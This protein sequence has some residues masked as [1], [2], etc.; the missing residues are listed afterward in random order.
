MRRTPLLI[1]AC[2]SSLATAAIAQP[3]LEAAR[4]AKVN[5]IAKRAFATKS[6]DQKTSACFVRSYDAAHLARHPKQ[7]V[8]AMKVLVAAEKLE[9]EES[10]SFSFK[11][12]AQVRDRK[13]DSAAAMDCGYAEASAVK[14]EG[15]LISCSEGCEGGPG[16]VIALA[17]NGKTI[18]VKLESISVWS[19]DDPEDDSG[20]FELKGG[21][22]DRVF[23]LDRAD[24]EMCRALA[25]DS[26]EVAALQPK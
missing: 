25:E 19:A 2:L 14:R 11:L 9:G 20:R 21:A 13:G 17:P 12:R 6:F 16:V 3:D 7:T 23:R 10:L 22:D 4:V 1:A 24:P 8:S 5:D 18:T 15:I 26:N